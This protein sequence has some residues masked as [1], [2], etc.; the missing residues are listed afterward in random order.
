MVRWLTALSACLFHVTFVDTIVWRQTR[1]LPAVEAVQAAAADE[2][3]VYAINNTVVAKY[4]RLTAQRL[5]QSTGAAQH[6]NSGF[7]WQGRLFCAHSN[8]PTVPEQS[9]IRVLDVAT[10]QLTTFKDFG[11]FGGSLTWCVRH[12]GDWWCH[13]AKYG[14]R[15]RDSFLVRLGPDWQVRGRWTLPDELVAQLGRYSLSGGIWHEGTLLVTGHD[16]PVLFR[17]RVPKS[18][19][20]LELLGSEPAPFTGQG[21]AADPVTGGLLGIHR[22]QRRVLFAER[23]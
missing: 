2:Q 10:M 8:Y 16:D 23:K 11:D 21:I 1:E 9:E 13:F 17:L 6:L 22:A 19:Q 4:D 3:F 7:F 15:N 20:V 14:E 5:A 18:G 12:E